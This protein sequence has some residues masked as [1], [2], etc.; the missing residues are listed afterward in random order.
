VN[1]PRPLSVFLLLV[2][3]IGIAGAGAGC[4]EGEVAD[5]AT[6]RVYVSAPLCKG[7]LRELR[8]AGGEAGDLKARAVCLAPVGRSRHGDLATAGANA[9][10]ATEDSTSVAYLEA[11]GPAARFTRSVV[12]AA[13]IAWLE[14]R[15]GAAGAR[16]VLRAL[17]ERGSASPRSAVS[18]QVG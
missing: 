7:A 6:V 3:A 14:T 4:G 12:E 1:R 17:E 15:S 9:R 11:P 5:G 18:D 13:G 16:R 8:R 10:R 2:F